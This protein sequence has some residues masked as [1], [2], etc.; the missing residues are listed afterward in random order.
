MFALMNVLHILIFGFFFLPFCFLPEVGRGLKWDL[1]S[2]T[3]DGTWASVVKTV[4]SEPVD[5]PPPPQGTPFWMYSSWKINS[6]YL[7]IQL[8]RKNSRN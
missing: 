7:S 6:F 5:P 4:G 8:A 2:Q 3:R 1:S